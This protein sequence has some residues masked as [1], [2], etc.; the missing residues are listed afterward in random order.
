MCTSSNVFAGEQ[1]PWADPAG[2]PAGDTESVSDSAHLPALCD[3]VLRAI[4][5]AAQP[6][7]LPPTWGFVETTSDLHDVRRLPTGLAELLGAQFSVEDLLEVGVFEQHS[8]E[9]PT[10]NRK[11]SVPSSKVRFITECEH[12]VDIYSA[13]GGLVDAKTPAVRRVLSLFETGNFN[14]LPV[15]LAADDDDVSLL[16]CLGNYCEWAAGLDAIDGPDFQRIF[17]RDHHGILRLRYRLVLVGWRPATLDSRPAPLI[18]KILDWFLKAHKLYE[19]DIE[20]L[21]GVWLPTP[22]TVESIRL[23]IEFQDEAIIRKLIDDS[24]ENSVY[25]PEEAYSDFTRPAERDYGAALKYLRQTIER[26]SEIPFPKMV[27]DAVVEV[28]RS[29][30]KTV[31]QKFLD[32]AA[33][34]S[35]PTKKML[36]LHAATLAHAWLQSQSIFVDAQRVMANQTVQSLSR[37][38]PEQFKNQCRLI[39]ELYKATK[40]AKGLKG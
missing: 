37:P 16:S 24:L 33:A 39:D 38:S 20:E 15:L 9:L 30:D 7:E 12:F 23:A 34:T 40:A 27:R 31:V 13:Q 17:T 28:N 14:P 1:T 19:F 11:L 2:W 10:L 4:Y 6:A 8:T 3:R 32:E 35:N 18:I 22:Q 25:T 21:V 26:C 29:Y 5:E 36:L